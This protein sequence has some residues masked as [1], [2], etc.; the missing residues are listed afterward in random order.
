[1][2]RLLT[3]AGSD[4]CGGAGVQADMRIAVEHGLFPMS[5]ITA[6]TAQTRKGV[7]GV[8]L[9]P[10]EFVGEQI[11]AAFS[12]ATPDVI[13]L[14]MLGNKEIVE[15][16]AQKLLE[17]NAKKVV[18]DTVFVSTSGHELLDKGAIS[19]LK[20]K[21]FPLC[22]VITPNI[23]E[24]EILADMKIN[25]KADMEKCAEKLSSIFPNIII[26]TGGHLEDCCDDLLLADGKITWFS[27]E[28]IE[29]VNTHGTGCTFSAC[30]ACNLA[31]GR[32]LK[33][34]VK[35]AKEYVAEQIL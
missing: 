4:S 34:S 22:H 3:I 33:E 8:L 12:D 13:K 26:I 32:S 20:E 28:K 7:R 23:P 29:G 14:G 10:P 21:L 2:K 25:S 17:H 27:G 15:V 5:A 1:L 11:D 35:S 19:A 31:M 30:L 18:F 16:V 9:T 24:A 6:L